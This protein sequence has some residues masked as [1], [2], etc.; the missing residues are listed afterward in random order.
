MVELEGE[1]GTGPLEQDEQLLAQLDA[2][3]AAASSSSSSS[4]SSQGSGAS[5][6]AEDVRRRRLRAAVVYRAGQK[7]L[8][9]A[10]LVRAKGE[11]TRLLAL[12][13]EMQGR[14]EAMD[15][16]AGAGSSAAQA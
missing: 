15:R 3:D 14:Q 7:R 13:R 8:A 16:A 2:Q 9:R 4:G 6:A 11:L 10:W 12:M 5:E 1:E